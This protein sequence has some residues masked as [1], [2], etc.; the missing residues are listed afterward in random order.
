MM[1]WIRKFTLIYQRIGDFSEGFFVWNPWKDEDD[2]NSDDEESICQIVLETCERRLS[3]KDTI[4]HWERLTLVNSV[5][6]SMPTYIMSLFPLL[7]KIEHR[8]NKIRRS[9]LWYGNKD[10]VKWR[11]ML[12]HKNDRRRIKNLRM[13]NKCLLMKW[14]WRF[15]LEEEALW[16]RVVRVK[17]GI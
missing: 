13:H 2:D 16:N 17:Y 8:I 9:L 3:G 12:K 4:Y 10:L 6:N 7:V 5:L 11:T 14:L 15:N 1:R